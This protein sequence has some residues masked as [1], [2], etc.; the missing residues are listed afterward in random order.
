MNRHFRPVA[1]ASLL[2]A[3]ACHP[4]PPPTDQPPKPQA[5]QHT[6]MR[7]AIKKPLDQAKAVEDQVQKAAEEQRKQIDAAAQ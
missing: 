5:E 4:T 3:S 2:L 6:E 1:F 7:D